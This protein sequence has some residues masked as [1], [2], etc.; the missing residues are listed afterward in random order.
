MSP[1]LLV[2]LV[3]ALLPRL[4]L[5]FQVRAPG[6]GRAAAMAAA[7]LAGLLLFEPSPAWFGLAGALV[8]LHALATWRERRL[9]GRFLEGFGRGEALSRA[10]LGSLA[11]QVV[12]LSSFAAPW[13][14]LRF[15]PGLA[16][17]AQA[18]G[19][20]SLLLAGWGQV[21]WERVLAVL[22]GALLVANEANLAIL[23]VIY[24]FELEPPAAPAAGGRAWSLEGTLAG[25][26]P[27]RAQAREERAER[28][29]AAP[30]ARA[31]KELKTGAVI[32]L[33]ERALV[34][35][36]VLSGQYAAIGLILAAKGFT[37]YKELERRAFAEYVLVGTLLSTL[38]AMLAGWWVGRLLR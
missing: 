38:L 36:L 14:G 23:Y 11:A 27:L 33:V 16:D 1:E 25:V 15:H 8:A 6:W 35:F 32:G 20:Y 17:L 21:E 24:R 10:R 37:R 29:E 22:L 28:L 3:A 34:Y 18:A 30:Q 5:T 26:L 7:Q 19:G 13:A 4:A 12:L 2:L 31:G 9:Q